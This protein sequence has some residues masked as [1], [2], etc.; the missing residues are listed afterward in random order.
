MG[1]SSTV[2]IITADQSHAGALKAALAKVSESEVHTEHVSELA[3]A[4]A[5][6]EAGH[7]EA[8]LADL[9]L[10]DSQ[11]ITTFEALHRQSPATPIITFS[12]PGEDALAIETVQRGA[13]GYLPKGNF[14]IALIT[15]SMDNIIQRRKMEDRLYIEKSRAQITLNSISDAVIST[16][17]QGKV[18]YM[19]AAA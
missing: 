1:N 10:S 6:M 14:G 16:D 19:N 2:L 15:R 8:I 12:D 17:T 4:L 5:R 13:H 7:L 11:G 3:A 18:D 9:N